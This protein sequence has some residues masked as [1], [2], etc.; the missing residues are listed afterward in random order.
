MKLARY[1]SNDKEFN[2]VVIGDNVYKLSDGTEPLVKFQ[3]LDPKEVEKKDPVS[4][5]RVRF[6]SPVKSPEKIICVAVNYRSHATEQVLKPPQEPYFFTKFRNALIGNGD[7]LILPKIS[8]KMDWEV[9]L[10]VIIGK[11][12][13]YIDKKDAFDYIAGYSVSNDVSYRDLQFPPGWTGS[14]PYGQNFVKGKSL[15]SAFP[16]GPW[17]VTKDEIPDP[18]NLTLSLSVNGKV[19]QKSTTAEMVFGIDA[20][21]EYASSGITLKPG[22]IISTGTPEGVAMFTGDQFLKE[23]DL[24]EA[25]V[26]HIG[27]LRN[28]VVAEK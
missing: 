14:S 20:L 8:K 22:D 17:V 9:E 13:K 7:P 2:G 1:L 19:K 11:Q 3:S 18:S 23:G 5:D 27:T 28:R 21:I 10:S 16:L 15:D 4:L 26:E 24:V 25:S 6:L 12:G